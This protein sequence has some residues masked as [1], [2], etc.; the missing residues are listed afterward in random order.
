MLANLKLNDYRNCSYLFWIS[1]T[2]SVCARKTRDKNFNSSRLDTVSLV[3]ILL[4]HL[5]PESRAILRD[6]P[7][8]IRLLIV[9]YISAYSS[10]TNWKFRIM[11]SIHYSDLII[12]F[13]C[14]SVN[15]LQ[16]WSFNNFMTK[17]LKR[18]LASMEFAQQHFLFYFGGSKH[19]AI[20]ITLQLVERSINHI[21]K[22]I[23]VFSAMPHCKA[24]TN[25]IL[26]KLALKQ[27]R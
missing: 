14:V 8:F 23:L 12:F 27:V 11:R 7:F 25:L 24:V 18:Y 22:V 4:Y 6:Y 9:V 21:I 10:Q 20:I 17:S 19:N 3:S 15:L 5:I 2:I 13:L 16:Q 26:W 1:T